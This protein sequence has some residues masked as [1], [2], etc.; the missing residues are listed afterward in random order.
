VETNGAT[1]EVETESTIRGD[2]S[3]TGTLLENLFRNAIEHGS[4][5]DGSTADSAHENSGPTVVV[6]ELDGGYGFFVEDDGPGM[7]PAERERAF[8]SGYTTNED[9]T[10]FGLAIVK[11]IVEAHG[12]TITATE[13]PSGGARFEIAGVTLTDS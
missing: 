13:S 5:T 6:G 1:I 2:Q 11:Q 3:R 12:W 4:E 10:G 9:G 7:T 8:E